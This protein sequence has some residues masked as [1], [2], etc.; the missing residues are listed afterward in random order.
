MDP[1][2]VPV[3]ELGIEHLRL[4]PVDRRK[5]V[6]L[7]QE[8][9]CHRAAQ[10]I[11]ALQRLVLVEIGDDLGPLDL[12]EEEGVL[13]GR[14][15]GVGHEVGLLDLLVLDD[16]INAVRRI[17]PRTLL[18]IDDGIP[19]DADQGIEVRI[20]QGIAGQLDVVAVEADI[21]HGPQERHPGRIHLG[22]IGR[23]ALH[24]QRI[25]AGGQA[26][27][28]RRPGEAVSRL[29]RQAAPTPSARH[30]GRLCW[31][32]LLLLHRLGRRLLLFGVGSILRRGVRIVLLRLLLPLPGLLGRLPAIFRHRIDAQVGE[33]LV[34]ILEP[35]GVDIAHGDGA[36]QEG[37]GAEIERVA[38]VP[39]LADGHDGRVPGH[40]DLRQRV[41]VLEPAGQAIDVLGGVHHLHL[42]QHL[43]V[44]GIPLVIQGI[45]PGLVVL[46]QEVDVA[47][48][49]DQLL[50]A[51]IPA[52][53]GGKHVVVLPGVG[54]I[55]EIGRVDVGVVF[56]AGGL[57]EEGVRE[58]VHVV[59]ELEGLGLGII[60]T[61]AALDD[62]AVL[63]PHR[64]AVLEDGDAVL[65]IVVEV[66]GAEDVLILVLQLDNPAAELRKVLIDNIF[67]GRTAE[68]GP[69]LD[70][71]DMPFG[72]NDVGRHVPEGGIAEEVR[73]VV[74]E[75]GGTYHL[76]VVLAV[77]FQQAG[78]LGADEGDKAVL[79][80]LPLGGEGGTEGG[81][82]PDHQEEPPQLHQSARNFSAQPSRLKLHSRYIG[83]MTMY[84]VLIFSSMNASM[85][86]ICFWWR[87][88]SSSW[89]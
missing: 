14:D 15:E 12:V 53:V 71:L 70:D 82:R 22:R 64:G 27:G 83:S 56:E 63:V 67:Q 51:V 80:R 17:L 19:V 7:L 28:Q 34:G 35:G 40:V 86:R 30:F 29:L 65:R 47:V 42:A 26:V 74:Q 36:V 59:H 66:V 78:G 13:L 55:A 5:G 85:A 18:V 8:E 37:I 21:V 57:D 6:V 4:H 87:T 89:V 73:V 62:L 69:V 32:L 43:E 24:L 33:P 44:P 68:F 3:L 76:A 39:L 16:H 72:E 75:T 52:V 41:G 2:E 23:G 1:L 81:E 58:H 60:G 45:G 10:R 11:E 79:P 61:E 31:R 38:P 25:R 84:V 48:E 50:V 88:C 46:G 77:H 9:E 20:S 54:G 49:E